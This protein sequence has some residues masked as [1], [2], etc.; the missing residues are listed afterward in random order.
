MQ[1]TLERIQNW[2]FENCDGEW[3]HTYQVKIETLDN[4]GWT[5]MIDLEETYLENLAFSK[6]FQNSVTEDDWYVF[7]VE[8]KKLQIACGPKNLEQV[9]IIFLDEVIQNRN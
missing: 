6:E 9:L 1:T 3:E 2:Y 4:P 5:I 7:R 8:S